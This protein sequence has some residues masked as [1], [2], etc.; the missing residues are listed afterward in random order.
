MAAIYGLDFRPVFGTADWFLVTF[1]GVP[2]GT[3]SGM[4]FRVVSRAPKQSAD[5]GRFWC[6][7]RELLRLRRF[8]LE[9]FAFLAVF[10]NRRFGFGLLG[11][12][13]AGAALFFGVSGCAR[14]VGTVLGP[15]SVL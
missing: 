12:V 9:I 6:S 13:C 10:G 7:S 1:W 8:R 3:A 15:F 5:F 14:T 11:V 2:V 4:R